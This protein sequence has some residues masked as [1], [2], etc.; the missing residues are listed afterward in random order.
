MC[1]TCKTCSCSKE[2]KWIQKATSGAKG[3]KYAPRGPGTLTSQAKRHGVSV[4]QFAEDVERSPDKYQTITH[5]R[6]NLYRT[7]MKMKK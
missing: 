2:K 6:V 3:K 7:L 1:G 4:A 5:Q